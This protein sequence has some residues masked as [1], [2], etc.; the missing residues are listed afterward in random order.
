MLRSL[1][2][3]WCFIG[4]LS[5]AG[6]GGGSSGGNS[7]GAQ[8]NITYTG[9][10]SQVQLTQQN[11][12]QIVNA[13]FAA[14]ST[15]SVFGVNTTSGPPIFR[16]IRTVASELSEV[17]PF[18]VGQNIMGVDIDATEACIGGGTV[19]LTGEVDEVSGEFTI[20]TTFNNCEQFGTT[21]SGA[22]DIS[23]TLNIETGE[24]VGALSAETTSL[25]FSEAQF[26]F[27]MS[28][29]FECTFGEF[30][31]PNGQIVFNPLGFFCVQNLL[32]R[33]EVTLEVFRLSDFESIF[34]DN[35]DPAL[36]YIQVYQG[37]YFH[38]AFGFVDIDGDPDA[39]E[40]IDDRAVFPYNTD[41]SVFPFAGRAFLFG[42]SG[43]L[44]H[45]SPNVDELTYQLEI[46]L[47]YD[48]EA[49]FDPELIST[50]NW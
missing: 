37:R 34:I 28:G 35:D 9:I 29:S 12:P 25:R 47:D 45:I 46:D 41:L 22:I 18:I 23:G 3:I 7:G 40:G 44:A 32:L 48:P 38:P 39:P 30:P 8:N 5:L 21:L 1:P 27:A 20:E 17:D 24:F 10:T 4:M 43:T 50:E 6:C 26:T 14:G 19:S 49:V 16:I 33:D 31:A 2:Y 11:T 42:S 36:G 15:N 13:A